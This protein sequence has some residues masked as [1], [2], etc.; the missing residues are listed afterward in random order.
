[1]ENSHTDL[2]WS[3][4]FTATCWK[5]VKINIYRSSLVVQQ[6]K[7]SALSLLWVRVPSLALQLPHANGVTKIIYILYIMRRRM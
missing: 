6:V 1:M 2:V 5:A 4:Y 7:D 3:K